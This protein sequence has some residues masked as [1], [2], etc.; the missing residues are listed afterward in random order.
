MNLLR[1]L[2][3]AGLC[4]LPA[5]AGAMDL[6]GSVLGADRK[7]LAGVQVR[8]VGG[9]AVATTDAMGK[10]NI[11]SSSVR[12]GPREVRRMDA[13]RAIVVV[14]NGRLRL[15][16]AGRDLAGRGGGEYRSLVGA[17]LS[18]GRALGVAD[19]LTYSLG[20]KVLL[21]DTVSVSQTGIVRILD[22]TF[23]P[24]IVYGYLTDSRDGQIYRAVRIGNQVWMA[25]N[26][27]YKKGNG[28]D[29]G[30][31][32]NGSPDS[33]AKYGRLYSWASL[34]NI[35]DSCNI[36][37]CSSQVQSNH[38]GVCPSGWHVP[39]DVEW[40][41]LKVAVDGGTIAGTKLKSTRGWSNAG[42]GTDDHGFRALPGGNVNGGSSDYAGNYG[43]WW[44]TTEFNTSRAWGRD[45]GDS[46]TD[47]GRN[48]SY[49]TYGFSARCLEDHPDTSTAL[50]VPVFNP[51]GGTYS[52]GQAVTII[53]TS[54][55]TIYYTT[56]GTIPT[57]SSP[58]YTGAISVSMTTTIN[59]IAVKS[60]M[61]NSVEASVTYTIRGDSASKGPGMKLIPAGTFTMGSP[62]TEA[63]RISDAEAQHRVTLSNF[64]MDSTP[65]TQGQ[66]QAVMSVNP[67]NFTSC[68]ATCPVER[69]TWFDA[70]LYCNARSKLDGLDT[71]YTYSSMTGTYGN[72]VTGMGG[73]KADLNESGYRL[74]TEA[75]WEYAARGGTTTAY[76]WGDDASGDTVSKYAWY[77]GNSGSSTKSV[78]TKPANPFCLY[79][80]AGN[81]WQWTNDWYSSPYDTTEQTDPEGP[82]SGSLRVIRGG[83]WNYGA[84]YLRSAHRNHGFTDGR[85]SNIGFRTVRP[86]P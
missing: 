52:G 64:Y 44:S 24:A 48:V 81:V 49:K 61:A 17:P 69:V 80:M 38:R 26:L 37:A 10:W 51:V 25:E 62:V 28:A 45:E 39:S 74:P 33:G 83:G 86:A 68:G 29:S 40:G 32:Y 78:A 18:A 11:Q 23:N 43:N 73:I 13:P 6:S 77:S 3:S 47:V 57:T 53:T 2:V 15:R 59:A 72:G 9:N 12:V 70:V 1:L 4:A 65:V 55:A 79:D 50:A 71:V 7:P 67:S 42:N 34:M 21:R 84:S 66:Y 20:G 63:N 22:S 36:K 16:I 82:S 14:E 30:W 54:G 60:G 75:Q 58:R 35:A 8:L 41:S 19:T 85:G 46:Y 27:N 56:D 76:Y 5:L 31:W